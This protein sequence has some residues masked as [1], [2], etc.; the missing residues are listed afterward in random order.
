MQNQ[1]A[2]HLTKTEPL[3]RAHKTLFQHQ[4]VS[5]WNIMTTDFVIFR[6]SCEF[7]AMI[8][9]LSKLWTSLLIR[10]LLPISQYVISKL[11]QLG[12]NHHSSEATTGCP[13]NPGTYSNVAFVRTVST[14]C[15]VHSPQR[16]LLRSRQNAIAYRNEISKK[17]NIQENQALRGRQKYRGQASQSSIRSERGGAFILL[18]YQFS[19]DLLYVSH[20]LSHC[21]SFLTQILIFN[22]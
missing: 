2:R 11:F 1:S 22:L 18:P 3:F 21:S 17:R 20:L 13:T 8:A 7:A 16:A 14:I 6:I 15:G 9:S 4:F 12:L 10:H 5:P 19:R